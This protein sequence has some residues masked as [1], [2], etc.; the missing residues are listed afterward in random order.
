MTKYNRRHLFEFHNSDPKLIAR[1]WLAL[2]CYHSFIFYTTL[3]CSLAQYMQKQ[4]AKYWTE[5]K[6]YLLGISGRPLPE[7][8]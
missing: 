7:K 8:Q 4:L 6:Y 3:T 2:K 1:C 5:Q